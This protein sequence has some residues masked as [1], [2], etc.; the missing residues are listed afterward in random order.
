M[1]ESETDVLAGALLA[2]ILGGG[3]LA[4]AAPAIWRGNIP[5]SSRTPWWPFG[6][7][8]WCAFARSLPFEAFHFVT[9]GLLMLTRVSLVIG[10][11]VATGWATVLAIMFFNRPRMLVP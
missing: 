9:I 8:A 10:I 11:D 3:Y 1:H 5:L 4:F 2:L 7:T 6:R